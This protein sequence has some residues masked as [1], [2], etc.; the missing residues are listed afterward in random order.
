MRCRLAGYS[1]WAAWMLIIRDAYRQ[2]SRPGSCERTA[3]SVS[4]SS[5]ASLV[6]AAASLC[7]VYM[8]VLRRS[9]SLGEGPRSFDEAGEKAAPL[10]AMYQLRAIYGSII[11][12]H[13]AYAHACWGRCMH[14]VCLG[15]GYEIARLLENTIPMPCTICHE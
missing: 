10:L 4:S 8:K 14:K 7:H 9:R 13:L 15:Q 1:S 6:F 12:F 3:F 2:A 11:R 5:T